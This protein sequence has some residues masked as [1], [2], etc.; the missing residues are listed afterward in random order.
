MTNAW[1][2][3]CRSSW[4]RPLWFFVGLGAAGVS[5]AVVCIVFWGRLWDVWLG[6]GLLLALV[7]IASL[8]RVTARVSADADGLHSRT[9][10]RRRSVPWR[11][12]A[13]LRVRL[14]YANTPRVQE[15]RRVSLVLRDGRKRLLPLPQSW[16]PHDPDFDGQLA[17]L[18]ALHRRHG[19]PESS[20][21]PVVSS[22]TAGRGW[23]G[24]LGLC[25]LLLAGAGVAAWFV[26]S[27]ASDER[28]WRS[29]T[30]CTAGTPTT[31]RD[32]CLTT[33]SAVIAR[34]ESNPP[35]QR[36][37]L[38]FTDGRPLERLDVSPEA[39]EEFQAGD[40][41]ELT[42]WRGQVREVAG[43]GHVWREHVPGAGELAVVAAVFALVAGYPGAQV[44]L[45][46]RGRR[47]PDD[48]VLPS[49]LP[50]GAALIGTALWLLPLCYLHPTTLFASPVP[51]TWAAAGSL[52]TLALF[53]WA[54]RATRVRTPGAADATEGPAETETEAFFAARFLEHTDYNPHGFG[55]HIVLGGGP[56]AV[57]PH[58]GP[59]RFAAK[60]IPV[61]RLTVANVRR[62]RGSDGDTVP[63]SWH[64]AELHDG[65]TPVRLAA[66][67]DDLARIIRELVPAKTP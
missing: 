36:S 1:E 21:I 53:A 61:E 15:T 29:A 54:W 23:A 65:G 25:A 52:V 37:W 62:A 6:V 64:I 9:L 47:L 46:L 16:E 34:T 17:A 3:T 20:H 51:I 22:R 49:A 31:E 32:T 39:A 11:D 50:F 33:L 44:L 5:L 38:Y 2:V 60:R 28:A 59:G 12:I 14:K 43:A 10:L 13:D 48:E 30:P 45:R 26:P 55:T 67:P 57:T 27:M 56:P 63:R 42:V 66:A 19:A 4:K 7:G 8:R 18:R 40:S 35:K 24:S 58:P 41:V